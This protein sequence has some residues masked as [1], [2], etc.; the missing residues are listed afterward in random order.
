[1]RSFLVKSTTSA[2][3]R[4]SALV[5]SAATTA[6]RAQGCSAAAKSN[7]SLDEMRQKLKE[8]DDK[9]EHVA[10]M[11]S[12]VHDAAPP[13][14]DQF[15]PKTKATPGCGA[16]SSSPA[17]EASSE[18]AAAAAA[19]VETKTVECASANAVYKS[20]PNQDKQRSA[21]A[22]AL[23]KADE[24]RNDWTRDEVDA[25]YNLP[26]YEL[27]SKAHDVHRTNFSAGEVQ[28]CTLLSI[29]TG[30]CTENCKYC[31]QSSRYRT[32]VKPSKML[33]VDTVLAAA[34]EA[35]KGGSTRF[36][37]GS[38]WRD[39]GAKKAFGKVLTMVEGISGMGMEVCCTLGMIDAEQ[40][41]ALKSA[42][43]K[44][45][46]HNLDTSPEFYPEIITTRT[47]SERLQTLKN[48]RDAGL[49]V[50][51]GGIIGLGESE[52]DRVGL[53]QTLATL[54]KHPESV[55][56]NALVSV[57]GTPLEGRG[58]VP[59]LDMVRMI[60]TARCVLPKSMV[61]LSA[62]R[63]SYNMSEQLLLFMAG[64]NSIFTGEKLLTTPNPDFDAD[65]AMFQTLGL[66]GK[67][68][69]IPAI[70]QKN[71]ESAEAEA[72]AAAKKTVA[73]EA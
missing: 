5:A 30:G 68:P 19:A 22:H 39:V 64:A 56:I 24:V 4:T 70:A 34:R 18:P 17:T 67:A 13:A 69:E 44:A 21:F 7:F 45:Y 15:I 53:I 12:F 43:L 20:K 25:I 2:S 11:S 49:S 63:Q 32:A 72:A 51:C 52:E 61:R 65:H 48:V 58:I 73:A 47:Y 6:I 46:N 26:L 23:I 28:R 54:G 8:A 9:G 71:V 41:K 60:A 31:P 59:V 55:P 42:G 40:A 66:S 10:K 27:L 3:L 16:A 50:C 33:D 29:K 62:G 14:A 38:A 37:M 35:K 57:A 1:M 36:C